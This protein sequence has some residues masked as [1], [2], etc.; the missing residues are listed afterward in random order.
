MTNS[1]K[2]SSLSPPDA[3]ETRIAEV[4]E[5]LSSA[6]RRA[7]S[8]MKARGAL[9]SLDT[10]AA[11]A[12]EARV[13][14]MTVSRLLKKMGFQGFPGLKEAL[15]TD[16]AL[17]AVDLKERNKQLL[18]GRTGLFLKREAEAVLALAEQVAQPQWQQ[19]VELIHGADD[20]VVAGFQ[21]LRGHVEDFARRLATFRD[22]VRYAATH[23]G[24]LAELI[25]PRGP[26]RARV[27]ILVDIVPYG[28]EAE[29]VAGLA[30][31]AGFEIVIVTDDLNQWAQGHTDT[32]LRARISTDLT[33]ESTGPLATLLS[34]LAQ[35]V[36]ERD[37]EATAARLDYWAQIAG[38]MRYYSSKT[39]RRRRPLWKASADGP[40][41]KA[42]PQ[43]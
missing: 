19:A 41:A 17:D 40:G 36:A 5:A 39:P 18:A 42:G 29:T 30:R 11:L 8:C 1:K 34:L 27:L 24:C 15:R 32:V 38:E 28:R 3:L 33:I 43:G 22:G 20:V 31:K 16:A 21:M 12:R 13:S 35:A 23:D 9:V 26:A 10:G 2:T 25:P 4:W 14:E 6:E 7:A 37:P